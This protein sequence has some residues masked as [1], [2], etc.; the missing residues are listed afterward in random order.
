M[1]EGEANIAGRVADAAGRITLFTV[2]DVAREQFQQRHCF[3]YDGVDTV[4]GEIQHRIAFIPTQKTRSID[5]AGTLSIDAETAVLKRS[6]VQ[7]TNLTEKSSIIA[8]NCVIDYA[9]I[10]PTLVL[11]Q[12]AR[13][14]TE[15]RNRIH[16]P[17]YDEELMA[18]AAS[19]AAL[20]LPCV[21]ISCVT[22][23]AAGRSTARL[24]HDDVTRSVAGSATPLKSMLERLVVGIV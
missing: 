13:C 9:E 20:G 21:A 4:E 15:D 14:W 22:N 19:A 23:W 7:H 2:S 12:H 18:K 8:T 11:E 17:V 3:W 16:R 1:G 6:A 24:S 5:W 10:V